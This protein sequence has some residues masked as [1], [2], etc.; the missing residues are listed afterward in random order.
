M[1][2]MMATRKPTSGVLAGLY[3]LNNYRKGSDPELVKSGRTVTFTEFLQFIVDTQTVREYS[4]CAL[5]PVL[6]NPRLLRD[7]V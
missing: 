5:E 1:A 7:K 3:I 2:P 6:H 4:R